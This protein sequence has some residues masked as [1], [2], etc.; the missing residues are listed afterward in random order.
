MVTLTF[1]LTVAASIVVSL[2]AMIV[3]AG[4]SKRIDANVAKAARFARY[5]ERAARRLAA[6]SN[7]RYQGTHAPYEQRTFFVARPSQEFRL[8]V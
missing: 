3:A 1:L 8:Y 2:V 7:A 6:E 5:D 4:L